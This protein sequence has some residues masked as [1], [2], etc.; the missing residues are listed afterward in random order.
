MGRTKLY[1]AGED[2]PAVAYRVKGYRGIAFSVFGWEIEPDSDTEWTGI[3]TRTGNV[4]AVMVG[5]DR[6]FSIEP[7]DLSPL[8]ENDYCFECGQIGCH[9]TR[10]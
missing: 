5:D 9:C 8:E 10:A 2:F 7:E 1:E 4:I 3:E 6:Q